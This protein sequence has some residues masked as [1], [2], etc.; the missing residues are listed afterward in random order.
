VQ[1]GLLA[2][3][4]AQGVGILR[5]DRRA[6]RR[7]RLVR[8]AVAR[9]RRGVDELVHARG[10]RGLEHADRALRVDGEVVQRTL[11]RRHDVT[12][13]REVK[14][15]RR[16]R[17]E[18]TV[19]LERADVRHLERQR[20]IVAVVLEVL[21]ASAREVVDHAHLEALRQ[22]EIDH[23]AADE[24]GAAGDDC[25][26][27]AHCGTSCLVVLTLK[28]LSSSKLSGSLPSRKATHRSRTASSIE[29]LGS[30]PRMS[31]IFLDDTW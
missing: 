29:R 15:V 6:L 25:D 31:R 1:H 20:R 7:R 14:D 9:R 26:R 27:T 22:E 21:A 4:L 23:V 8:D 19:R 28:Y 2:L 18:R 16:I 24:P 17:E 13:S 5:P 3:P 11:D 30:Q 12:D 10:A